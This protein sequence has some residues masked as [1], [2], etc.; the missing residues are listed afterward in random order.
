[1]WIQVNSPEPAAWTEAERSLFRWLYGAKR[2]LYLQTKWTAA[3]SL[4]IIMKQ[5]L[6]Q[7]L[8]CSTCAKHSDNVRPNNLIKLDDKL[9]QIF[10]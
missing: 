2:R 1:M 5:F 9:K 7:L 3:F 8:A 10:H 6:Q 4:G